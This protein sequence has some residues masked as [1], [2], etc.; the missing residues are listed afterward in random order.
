[1]A[2]TTE[3]E[4]SIQNIEGIRELVFSLPEGGGVLVLKGDNA[5]GKSTAIKVLRALTSGQGRLSPTDHAKRG[6]ASGLGAELSVTSQTRHL[7]ECEA[8]SLEGKFSFSDLVHPMAKTSETRDKIRTKAL[9]GLTGV[10]ADPA[11]FYELAGGKEE[12]EKIARPE[13]LAADDLVE[14]AARVKADVEKAAR[15]HEDQAENAEGHFKALH[16]AAHGIDTEAEADAE[17]LQGRLEEAIRED[18]RLKTQVTNAE[19]AKEAAEIARAML[20]E[21]QA[22]YDGPSLEA[23]RGAET[24]AEEKA[25]AAA[26]RLKIAQAE[27][28]RAE[29]EDEAARNRLTQAQEARKSAESYES[30][31]QKW[32]E[33]INATTPTPPSAE[34]LEAAAQKVAEA[35][36]AVEQGVRIREAKRQLAEAAKAQAEAK[37]HRQKARALRE[38]ARSVDDVLSAAIPPGPLRTE[39]GRL[40]LD[41]ARGKGVPFDECST[42]EKWRVALPYGIQSVGE[43]GVLPVEQDAWQDLGRA[44]RV[45]VIRACLAA[46]VWIVTGEVTDG[47]LRAEVYDPDA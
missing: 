45:E 4:I 20:A 7:G 12:L 29:A 33:Q 28:A 14:Q 43:G 27:L 26:T 41:T 21:A 35:R 44:A 38:A 15:S 36:Q 22:K 8:P 17:V 16:E 31:I 11:L 24:S 19:D 25:A 18:S 3:K 1:M 30:A 9:I 34:A 47:D 6:K 40:V 32:R 23:A 10:E 42:G 13:T 39:G 5:A 37:T 2:T 46:K